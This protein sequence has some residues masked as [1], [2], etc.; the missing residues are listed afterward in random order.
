MLSGWRD[1][2]ANVP[3]HTGRRDNVRGL[4]LIRVETRGA[5]AGRIASLDPRR[6]LSSWSVAGDRWWSLMIGSQSR[7]TADLRTARGGE[8]RPLTSRRYCTYRLVQ[9]KVQ[10]RCGQTQTQ[11]TRR[12]RRRNCYSTHTY[13]QWVE[14]R[15]DS[16]SERPC[17]Y[18]SIPHL[19]WILC[20]HRA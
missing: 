10:F 7:S 16:H 9:E 14:S 18:L 11:W 12:R 2:N 5:S 17:I 8:P 4:P 19:H 1:F 13:K 6:Q 3:I 20:I 15:G